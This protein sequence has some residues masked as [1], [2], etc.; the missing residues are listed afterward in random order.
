M[1]YDG[2]HI[3]SDHELSPGETIILMIPTKGEIEGQL[4]WIRGGRAGVKF[5]D[6]GRAVDERRARLGI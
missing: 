4:R 1:S 2:C 6:G 5:L 3:W